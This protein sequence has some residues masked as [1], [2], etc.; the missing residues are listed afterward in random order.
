LAVRAILLVVA[1]AALVL[2]SG[3]LVGSPLHEAACAGAA[4]IWLIIFVR[5][6]R[7]AEGPNRRRLFWL[8]PLSVLLLVL[9]YLLW[10]ILWLGYLISQ[11]NGAAPM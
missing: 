2:L 10:P 3:T 7:G 4:V 6:Y 5:V 1:A 8:L 9:P 11:W